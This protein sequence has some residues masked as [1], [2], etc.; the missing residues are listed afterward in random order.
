MSGGR[1]S[2]LDPKLYV[3]QCSFNGVAG[4]IYTEDPACITGLSPVSATFTTCLTK[5]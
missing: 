1:E 3:E 4:W 2:G 5:A